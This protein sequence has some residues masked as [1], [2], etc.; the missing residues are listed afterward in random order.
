MILTQKRQ[1]PKSF[2]VR[3]VF[4]DGTFYDFFRQSG[5]STE[6]F[7]DFKT[8]LY[9]RAMQEHECIPR[10]IGFRGL[11]PLSFAWAS[12]NHR[13]K[14]AQRELTVVARMVAL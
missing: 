8:P 3:S 12:T 7:F 10:L 14:V 11:H 9:L 2:I 5:R 6:A 13:Y 4:S 1:Y